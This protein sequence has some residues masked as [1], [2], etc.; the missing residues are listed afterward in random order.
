MK[1]STTLSTLV[2]ARKKYYKDLVSHQL[3]ESDHHCR[4][5]KPL[6]YITMYHTHSLHQG[7]LDGPALHPPPGEVSNFENP[8]NLNELSQ[9]TNAICLIATTVAV[10]IRIYAKVGCLKKVHIEDCKW[11]SPPNPIGKE[12]RN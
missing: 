4:T 9:I 1:I 10:L 3:G 7:I 2:V 11:P 12:S 8:W 6:R 5:S